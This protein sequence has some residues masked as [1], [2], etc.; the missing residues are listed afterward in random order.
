MAKHIDLTS[1]FDNEKPTI[2]IGDLEFE[3][4]DE[5]TNVLMVQELMA[6]NSENE[7]E[8]MDKAIKQL[9]GKKAFEKI[10][11]MNLRMVE[12]KTLF[13]GIMAV[14]NDETFEETEKRFQN[15]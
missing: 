5:K 9:V 14:I 2:K 12:Y 3:V 8:M 6:E 10:E 13:I 11:K 1:K 4:N 7:Y 15:S